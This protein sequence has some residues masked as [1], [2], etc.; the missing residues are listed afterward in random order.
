MMSN[1]LRWLLGKTGQETWIEPDSHV[2]DKITGYF[3]RITDR[4]QIRDA[5]IQRY[6]TGFRIDKDATSG[7]TIKSYE[8]SGFRNRMM[9]N[10]IEI[11]SLGLGHKIVNALSNL[12]S[13][14][15]QNFSYVS[16]LNSIDISKIVEYLDKMRNGEQYLASLTS[17]DI[18]SI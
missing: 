16:K 3:G 10:Q 15:T 17:A 12:F 13:E 9:A 4:D 8:R 2:A 6:G 11:V 5:I 7:I 1:I 14:T 18:M